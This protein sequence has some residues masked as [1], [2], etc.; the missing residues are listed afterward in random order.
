MDL[1]IIFTNSANLLIRVLNWQFIVFGGTYAVKE[2][3]IFAFLMGFV[4]TVLRR[5]F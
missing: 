1:G 2:I 3:V 5:I 4:I